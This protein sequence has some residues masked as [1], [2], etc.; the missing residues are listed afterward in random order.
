[1]PKLAA[2]AYINCQ[3]ERCSIADTALC[4]VDIIAN[5]LE[6]WVYWTNCDHQRMHSC[7]A[8]GHIV[9]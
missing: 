3:L 4:R 2:K 9:L 6:D 5:S 7:Q 8:A 1:M